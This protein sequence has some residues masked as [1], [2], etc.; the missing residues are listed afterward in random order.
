MP[1]RLVKKPAL[2]FKLC[3]AL[4]I[5]AA[6]CSR[7]TPDLFPA[8]TAQS[9]TWPPA[10]QTA[11]VAFV[12]EI[13]SQKD[14][15]PSSGLFS[16]IAEAA[17]G[18]KP[19]AMVRPYGLA[20]HPD[21]GLLV[22]DPGARVVHFYDWQ[23]RKYRAIGA[24]AK[25][26]LASPVSVAAL[27]N[28]DILVADS[29]AAAIYRFARDGKQKELFAPAGAIARPVALCA[30]TSRS[31]VFAADVEKQDIA[32]MDSQGAI[33]R[34]LN[35]RGSA[36][37]AMNSPTHLALGPDGLLYIT[38]SLN[39]R[40]LAMTQ[41]G[42]LVKIIGAAGD[43]PGQFS[44]PKGIAVDNAG[45]AICVEGLYDALNFFDPQER[46][47][48]SLGQPGSAPGEFW[49]PAG[50]AFDR[51]RNLLFVADSYNR[52]IQVFRL[53]YGVETKE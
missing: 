40:V 51:A 34:R 48:L 3:L 44:K 5:A 26:P 9:L 28:G 37:G 4:A 6:A 53:L 21:G 17:V 8:T 13:R 36:A 25:P 47:L 38:D 2:L 22:A 31:L 19:S 49:L 7:A 23:Q 43:A 30:D 32:V 50:L 52:R 11:R 29:Q 15:F 18:P 33:L 42:R 10:P 27:A 20:L 35:T 14:L 46:L 16:R 12:R 39:F 41:E 45:N 24:N 1:N